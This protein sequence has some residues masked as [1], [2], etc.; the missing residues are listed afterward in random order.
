M[1]EYLKVPRQEPR[2]H[3]LS[4]AKLSMNGYER[5]GKRDLP[6]GWE[7][8]ALAVAEGRRLPI[9]GAISLQLLLALAG[10]MPACPTGRTPVPRRPT[11]PNEAQD[12][13]SR[14]RE[15]YAVRD[16]RGAA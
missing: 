12:R 15:Y 14:S 1:S 9:G 7:I 10:K 3:G 13:Q 2:G 4:D 11:P 8:P 5:V 6:A 16:V